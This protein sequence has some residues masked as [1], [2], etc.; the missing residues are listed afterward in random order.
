M[1]KLGLAVLL[2]VIGATAASAQEIRLNLGGDRPGISVRDRDHW[3]DDRVRVRR[4]RDVVTTGSVGC[5]TI[6][7]RYRNHRGQMV[8]RR[9]QDCD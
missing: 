5:R 1:T 3:R 8:T 4:H 7:E 9:I 6:T 2:T